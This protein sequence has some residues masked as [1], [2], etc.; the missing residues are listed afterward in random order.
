MTMGTLRKTDGEE[1]PQTIEE[2]K[3][4]RK[5]LF[6]IGG[7]VAL[8]LLILG[9]VIKVPRSVLCSGY[10]TT[11]DYAEVRPAQTGKIAEILVRSGDH[12]QAGALLARLEDAE[13]RGALAE[14]RNTV[15]KVQAQ[16]AR[17]EGEVTLEAEQARLEAEQV[18]RDRQGLAGVLTGSPGNAEVEGPEAIALRLAREQT[19]LL[20]SRIVRRK[21]AVDEARRRFAMDVQ[22]AGLVLENA[23]KVSARTEQ[24]VAAGLA[25]GSVL[26]EAKL[27]EQLAEVSLQSLK[28]RDP[29]VFDQEL[30]AMELELATQQQQ[31]QL[32]EAQLRQKLRDL[33]TKAALLALR[34][35]SLTADEAGLWGRELRALREDLKSAEEAVKRAE[36]RLRDREVRAPISGQAVRYEFVVGEL[37]RPETVLYDLFG[38]EKQVLKLR[39]SEEYATRV[40]PGDA[41]EALIAPYRGLRR[42][43]FE[44]QVQVLR[45]AIQA[46]GST[47]YRL[48]YCSFE[49]GTNTVPPGSTAEARIYYGKSCLWLA[50][51]GLD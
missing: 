42:V 34:R 44:G 3:Q 18:A 19:S 45:N 14:A 10:V 23:Q 43:W 28:L 32:S 22:E 31:V 11:E 6:M 21:A 29:A 24:M 1:L 37:V 36:S 49:P 2:G 8:V 48:A 30:E 47:A 35:Q 13:E 33:E 5:R 46:E 20:K 17:R 15:A 12:V 4:R 25:A 40:K 26:Q 27:K 7:G 51:L 16:N 38:G 39:V 50:M 9:L 41:Y